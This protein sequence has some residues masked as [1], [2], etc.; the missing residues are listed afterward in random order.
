MRIPS[1]SELDSCELLPSSDPM[2][3]K[4]SREKHKTTVEDIKFWAATLHKKCKVGAP[5]IQYYRSD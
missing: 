5:T 1:R 4:Q 3:V 2:F